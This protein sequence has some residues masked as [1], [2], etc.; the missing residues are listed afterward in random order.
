MIMTLVIK[1]NK[2]HKLNNMMELKFLKRLI[3]QH[4]IFKK[5]NLRHEYDVST[6]TFE[7]SLPNTYHF[8]SYRNTRCLATN[9]NE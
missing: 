4:E 9:Q 5:K 6:L 2:S 3:V 8:R 7:Q 1:F